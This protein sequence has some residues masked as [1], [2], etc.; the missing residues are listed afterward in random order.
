MTRRRPM[1]SALAVALCVGALLVGACRGRAAAG[2]GPFADKVAEDVPK[3]ENV[4]GVK[5]KTPPKL[6]IRSRDEVRRFLLAKISEPD[7][8]KQFADQE[9]I[10][11]LLGLIRDTMHL[12]DFYVRVLTEQIMGFY[13]PKTKV[14]YVVDGAPEDYVGITIMHELIHALQ[15]QYVSL[16]SLEHISD[17]D[18]RALAAQAVVEG[19]ATYEQAY[20]MAGG[21][22]NIAAQLPGGWESIRQMIREAQTTQPIFASAPTVIQE[23]LLFPYINGSDFIRRFTARERGKLP[24]GDLPVSSKQLMH[25]S[26]YFGQPRD[27]PSEITLPK[28][29]GTVT[30]NDFGEFGTRLV[31][32][33]STK[34]QDAAI[35]ASNGWDGDRYALVKTPAGN[36]FVWAIAWDRREDAAEFMSAMDQVM[37]ERFNVQARV[38]G[39]K[40]RFETHTRTIELDAREIAGRPVVLYVDVPAGSSTN[41]VDFSKIKVVPR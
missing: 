2:S 41:L 30:E 29:P 24:F 17:D 26:A 5:F 9:S 31:I 35:R 7:A 28:I 14:L 19:Q 32:Y 22:G 13:D 18:D 10:Y 4:I 12:K 39:E 37:R 25:D 27:L 8:Q 20:I 6:E 3:I 1:R 36:A 15:D 11:K 34:A 38:T 23:T 40:R 21:A 33:A 16:D